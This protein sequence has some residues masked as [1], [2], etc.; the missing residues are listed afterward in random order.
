MEQRFIID[1][2]RD[3]N[4]KLKLQNEIL[5]AENEKLKIVHNAETTD[6]KQRV[7]DLTTENQNL[8]QQLAES[9]QENADFKTKSVQLVKLLK[10]KNERINQTQAE[11]VSEI[12]KLKEKLCSIESKATIKTVNKTKQVSASVVRPKEGTNLKRK[13]ASNSLV[14]KRPRIQY[15]RKITK[16]PQHRSCCFCQATRSESLVFCFQC[17][18][19][20]HPTCFI[21]FQTGLVDVDL[22]KEWFCDS[23]P[24]NES[25][26]FL[27]L[28]QKS[29]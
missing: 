27:A 11:S 24:P 12:K 5:K 13:I 15:I 3:H 1:D 29:D 10:T 28:Y 21:E 19:T 6:I 14:P 20:F 4:E 25:L 18:I 16:I 17:S 26:D 23:C 8:S 7:I 9:K 2:L 22:D